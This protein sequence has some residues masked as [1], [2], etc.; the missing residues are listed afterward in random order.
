MELGPEERA[1]ILSTIEDHCSIRGW[2]LLAANARTNHV[3][4]VVR[5]PGVP[6]ETAMTQFKAWATRRMR[7][8]G[9]FNRKNWTRHGST[10]YLWTADAVDEKVHYVEKFQ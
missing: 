3:H 10:I 1:I 4:V 8:A 6:P 7:E 5:C 2:L 9:F